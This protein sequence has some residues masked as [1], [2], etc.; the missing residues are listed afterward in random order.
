M[1]YTRT[2]SLSC[3]LL[4]YTLYDRIR[5][6]IIGETLLTLLQAVVA[7]QEYYSTNFIIT[8]S[9][10]GLLGFGWGLRVYSRNGRA[11]YSFVQLSIYLQAGALG[12]LPSR[13]GLDV[14]A[15]PVLRVPV[16]FA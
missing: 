16:F 11:V 12:A 13:N 2:Y 6:N 7:V 1:Y 8:M 4:L 15:L 9:R 3:T 5:D 10:S 14:L